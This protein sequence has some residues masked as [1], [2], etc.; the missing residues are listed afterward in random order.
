MRYGRA[1]SA[2]FAILGG[3][4]CALLHAAPQTGVLSSSWQFEFKFYDPQ[5]IALRLPGDDHP[6]TFWYML[7]EVTNN[8][9]E[10]RE[11]YPSFRLVTD[12]L[13]VVEGGA[14]ISP[15]VYDA[16]ITRHKAEFPFLAPP[17]KV[18][19]LLLQGEE[20][21]RASMAVFRAFNPEASGFTI[22]VSGLS[23]DIQRVANP[24]FDTKQPESESN[25]RS[26]ILRRTLA[27]A[28]DLPGDSTTRDRAVP[29]R[30]NRQWVMR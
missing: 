13:Q 8:T 2:F 4:G 19:G 14:D 29:I 15:G 10:D 9:G 30:R 11:F 18:T 16:I 20:N 21:A 5:R 3:P 23:G 26:F 17:T 12:T 22:Y 25:A 28:Y 7:F 27:V 6:T 24:S 1:V